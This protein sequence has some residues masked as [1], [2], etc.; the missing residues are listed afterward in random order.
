[1]FGE[2]LE[3]ASCADTRVRKRPHMAMEKNGSVKFDRRFKMYRP[4]NE[5]NESYE[6]LNEELTNLIMDMDSFV[7][8]EEFDALMESNP[9]EALKNKAEKSGISYGTLK[10]VF[11]R[12]VAAWRTGHRP[13]TTPTQWGLARVNSF[14]TKGKGTW[15]KADSDLAAKVRKEEYTAEGAETAKAKMKIASEKSA[16]TRKHDRMLDAAKER[17]K[18]AKKSLTRSISEGNPNPIK[19]EEGTDSLVNTYKKD[20]PGEKK[21]KEDS[22]LMKNLPRGTRVRFTYKTMTDA[23]ENVV[24]TVVGTETYSHEGSSNAVSSKGRLRVRDDSGKL[25]NVK[26]QDVETEE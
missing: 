5:I 15:G 11:D 17:D 20:T 3:E 6:D 1:M 16:D 18:A 2:A 26:H 4:K 22:P 13:G 9:T 19:R 12:G 8:S 7:M 21:L 10:K 24:G 25:Y 14:V 23:D